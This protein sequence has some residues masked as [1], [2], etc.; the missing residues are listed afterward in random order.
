MAAAVVAMTIL[1]QS[2][3][4]LAQ[5]NQRFP[6][7]DQRAEAIE[8]S[9]ARLD[10]LLELRPGASDP[11]IADR[12]RRSLDQSG[13]RPADGDRAAE[14][15]ATSWDALNSIDMTVALAREIAKT[16]PSD[17]GEQFVRSLTHVNHLPN[18]SLVPLPVGASQILNLM[19]LQ[20]A[21]RFLSKNGSPLSLPKTLAVS[22]T[23]VCPIVS[24][25]AAVIDHRGILFGS[26]EGRFLFLA[27]LGSTRLY[28]IPA[29]V[30]HATIT[31]GET[32]NIDAPDRPALLL[33]L[34]PSGRGYDTDEA[35]V[36]DCRV[37]LRS[38]G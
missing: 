4:S 30:R 8:V 3:D 1:S 22:A 21:I 38:A 27:V 28:L 6:L 29:E 16:L 11:A 2:T 19:L 15:F 34:K 31:A 14:S 36:G 37:S 9:L 25:T 20:D 13:G 32:L 12:L 18:R 33:T 17:V 26:R 23:P 5:Q 35:S 24:G 7:L 10:R